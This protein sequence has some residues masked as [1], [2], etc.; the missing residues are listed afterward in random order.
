MSSAATTVRRPR[1]V[2]VPIFEGLTIV[3]LVGIAWIHLLDLGGKMDE[4]PYLGVAYIGLIA[5]CVAAAMML[6]R[7]DR[8]GFL[9][10]G[11]LAAATFIGYCLSRTTGLPAATDDVGNWTETLCVWS[12]IAEGAVVALSA[13]ALSWPGRRSAS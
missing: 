10:A 12:L 2:T 11:G 7:R 8:R 9:V 13:A 1:R 3:G 5:G 4:T 6:G